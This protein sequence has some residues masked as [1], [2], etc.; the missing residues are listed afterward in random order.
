M[1]Q[2][3]DNVIADHVVTTDII[4]QCKREIRQRS[5]IQQAP[6][7]GVVQGA[8][9]DLRD[10]NARIMDDIAMIIEDELAAVGVA[11]DRQAHDRDQKR[12]EGVAVERGQGGVRLLSY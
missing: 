4:I 10:V 12:T 2:Y 11:V 6:E 8:K 9:A 5:V 1:D 3:V 7:R